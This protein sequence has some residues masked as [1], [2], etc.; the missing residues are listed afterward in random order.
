M[1][2]CQQLHLEGTDWPGPSKDQNDN[3]FA[4]QGIGPGLSEVCLPGHA[5]V[6][7]ACDCRTSMGQALPPNWPWTWTVRLEVWTPPP[8]GTV[9]E[10]QADQLVVT[11]STAVCMGIGKETIENV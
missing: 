7:Q 2:Q 8:Q 4:R 1:S 10:L 3:H 11:Q 5:W 6:L 9:Q